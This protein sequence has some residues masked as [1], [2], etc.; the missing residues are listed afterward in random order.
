[1]LSLA[2]SAANMSAAGGSSS[3]GGGGAGLVG[4]NKRQHCYLCD[5]PR[6]PWAMLQDFSEPVCRGCV[7]YEGPDRIELVIE[8]A[9]QMKRGPY[10]GGE[11]IPSTAP[12]SSQ[13]P[14]GPAEQR[15]T[16][17]PGPGKS[18]HPSERLQN[19]PPDLTNG[20]A[21]DGLNL[22]SHAHGGHHGGH[23]GVPSMSQRSSHGPGA[24][25]PPS[26]YLHINEG[27]PRHLAVD[28]PP[29]LQQQ[30]TIMGR[31]ESLDHSDPRSSVRGGPSS[32]HHMQINSHGRSAGPKRERDDD[33]NTPSQATS[34]LSNNGMMV[35]LQHADGSKR[36]ALDTISEYRPQLTRGDSLPAG[37]AVQFDPRDGGRLNH[38]E[39]P[40]RVASFDATSSNKVFPGI[41]SAAGGG[42]GG[43]R[44]G[45]TASPLTRNS[46]PGGPHQLPPGHPLMV[47]PHSSAGP[48]PPS[49]HGP[50]QQQ[51][52]QQHPHHPATSIN[53]NGG[54]PSSTPP[55]AGG[56][57]G[58]HSH[59]PSTT[60]SGSS[61]GNTA[62]PANPGK[63]PSPM[64]SLISV[65]DTILPVSNSPR[66]SPPTGLPPGA[67]QLSRTPSRGSQHSPSSSGS[68]TSRRSSG[69]GA[70]TVSNGRHG[71]TSEVNATSTSPS[72]PGSHYA[73]SD[74][75][76]SSGSG[77][78]N[79]SNATTAAIPPNV[80]AAAAAA[81]AAT[82]KCTICQERLEDTHFVQCP[83]ISHH[84]FC[85]PCSRDSIKQQGA[86]SE[87]YCPSG[88][89]CPL[90]GSNVPWAFM[91]GEIATI[92][93][94]EMNNKPLTKERET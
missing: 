25:G 61:G 44:G 73:G 65:A 64:Q 40:I 94:E 59:P 69:N 55:F 47:P 76:V 88:E 24:V 75:G 36:S 22:P 30:N 41:P 46:P 15:I 12:T 50:S 1:M 66:G 2:S 38:K 79:S 60:A 87:V 63:A 13:R 29:R 90:A 56:P 19:R 83:S 14:Q 21:S 31:M 8:S 68:A 58:S 74:S 20:N 17:T 35:Q 3:S 86:G 67:A 62:P 45:V 82:L 49:N 43:N 26:G 39:R 32:G 52:S 34:Y 57:P 77:S 16:T 89:K 93:G 33:D 54:P 85:F 4:S 37:L 78:S 80:A 51:S 48:L 10:P 18:N 7:N 6:T 92:L 72:D 5:L 84:K 53:I 81:A 42:G 9:R 23:P 27:R 11:S 70:A 71:S 28:Y 91:Q